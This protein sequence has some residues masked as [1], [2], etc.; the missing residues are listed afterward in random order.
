MNKILVTVDFSAN[1]RKTIRFAIQLA[2]QSKSEIIFF[3]LVTLIRPTSDTVWDF[4]YYAQYN[5][6]VL[7]RS[8][9]QLDRLI[10][11]VYNNKLPAGV[12]YS[13]VCLSGNNLGD[14]IISYAK[15]HKV[16]FICVGARGTS[17]VAKLFGTIA[18]HL[19]TN[20]PIPLFIIPKNYRLKPITDLC[21][22][23]DMENPETEIKKV[24]EL[25]KSLK[26]TVKVLHFDYEIELKE[27]QEK[28]TQ[29]AQKYEN[30]NVKFQYKKLNAL[31]P[32]NDH[33][34]KVIAIFK[35]SLVVL[36]T[37]QNRK[38]FDRLL[39]SSESAEL[40]FTA[41]VPLLVYR[42]TSK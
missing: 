30:K 23:S 4:T 33:L 18:S 21:Y 31:Y 22:A 38:W 42:K 35:P 12:K 26:T 2:S 3:H 29:I 17:I 28:L 1:S 24:V 25:A 27:N 9:D 20:S 32:L 11:E 8:K 13:C 41:K 5:D 36:F 10:K 16:D 14:Q 37:K 34:R 40:S 39:L 6:E 19:I 15:E 7:Q